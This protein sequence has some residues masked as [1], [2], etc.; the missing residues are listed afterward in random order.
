MSLNTLSIETNAATKPEGCNVM[1]KWAKYKAELHNRLVWTDNV[2]Y[3]HI[4]TPEE[5][6]KLDRAELHQIRECKDF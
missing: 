3:A 2:D 6:H 4:D 1:P 5:K